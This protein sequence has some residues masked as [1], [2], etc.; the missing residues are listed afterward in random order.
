MLNAMRG[1]ANLAEGSIKFGG[2]NLTEAE[3]RDISRIIITACGTSWHAAL[4]GEYLIE[5]FAKIPVEV[6]YASEFRYRNPIIQKNDILLVISQS[7]ETLDTLEALR[8]AKRKGIKVLGITNVV[9]STIARECDGG[10]YLHAGPEIGVASTKAFT[11]QVLVMIML[12]IYLG[13]LKHMSFYEG[14]R[15]LTELNKIPDKLNE[16]LKQAEKIKSIAKNINMRKIFYTLEGDLI[17]PLLLK[18]H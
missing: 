15:L 2:L 11:N 1:R 4:I 16:I 14:Q 10:I 8:E 9:G 12:A 18:V 7:G 17:I 3:A 13:R 6:D 5:T